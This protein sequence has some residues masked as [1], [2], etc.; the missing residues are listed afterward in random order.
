MTHSITEAL[1]GNPYPGRGIVVGTTPGGAIA[2][3]YFIMG[4][5]VNSR[6]RVLAEQDGAIFTRPVDLSLVSDPSLIIYAALRTVGDATVLTNG[7]QTD[8]VVDAL[9]DAGPDAGPSAGPDTGPDALADAG[10]DT[11]SDGLAPFSDTQNGPNPSLNAGPGAGPD[12][13]PGAGSGES[14]AVALFES[15]LRTR[16]FEPDAPNFTSRISALAQP[17]RYCLSQLK[18]RHGTTLRAFWEYEAAPGIGHLIHTYAGD[19]DPLPAFTGE[20]VEIAIGDD[21]G[22]WT[23]ECWAAL[24]TDNRISLMT[25]FIPVDGEPTTLV[26]NRFG[27]STP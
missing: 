11:L 13:G 10:P 3:A 22:A 20:P 19:G 21:Q 4:R 7:D 6:N 27:Q 24:D 15:A 25:R 9:A 17:G 12:A 23:N 8:T 1:A 14:R 26:V 2:L 18:K 16:T 5:S